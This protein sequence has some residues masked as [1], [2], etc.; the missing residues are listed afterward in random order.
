[1]TRQRQ[2]LEKLIKGWAQDHA[3]GFIIADPNSTTE[4]MHNT[5]GFFTWVIREGHA[6]I[7]LNNLV[8]RLE[9]LLE[10]QNKNKSIDGMFCIS[11]GNFYKYAEANQEDGSMVCYTCR[12]NPYV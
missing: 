6:N 10:S 8:N 1:M 2:L 9:M 4:A 12:I 3:T 11:C 7:D 5:S